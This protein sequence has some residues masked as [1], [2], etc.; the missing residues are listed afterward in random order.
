[1]HVSRLIAKA[2]A[3]LREQVRE[4]EGADSQGLAVTA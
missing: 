1:M 4:P 3:T 2:L